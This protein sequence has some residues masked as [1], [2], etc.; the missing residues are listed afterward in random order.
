M[1]EFN[2]AFYNGEDGYSDGDDAENNIYEIVKAGRN[3]DDISAEEM[4]WPAFY[5]LS[6]IRE[7]ICNWYPFKKNAKILEIGSGCGAITGVLCQNARMVTSIELSK[8]RASINFERNKKYKNLEIIVGNLNEIK[9]DE[10]YDYITLIGVL[11]YAGRFTEGDNPFHL[12]INNIKRFLKPDGAILIAIENRLGLKYFCGAPED[13]TGRLFD[14]INNYPNYNGVK[15]FSKS[16]LVEL[17]NECGFIRNRFYYPYPDYK[18]PNEIFTD[19]S[20]NKNKRPY[21]TYDVDRYSL[22]WETDMNNSLQKENVAFAFANSFFVEARET[23]ECDA[24]VL[25]VK[26]NQDRKEEFRVGTVIY[27]QDGKKN[28]EK[29]IFHPSAISHIIN[30]Y[31]NDNKKYGNV[32]TINGI[33]NDDSIIY[34]LIQSDSLSD[35]LKEL[36]LHG[37]A[38]E[39][40]DLIRDFFDDVFA[41][42]IPMEL[43]DDLVRV[44]GETFPNE[45]N[46]KC[47]CP[48]NIDLSPSNVFCVD[49]SYVVSD[50]E[51]VFDFPIP[52][53][54][55][56]WRAIRAL[57]V[58]VP[59]ISKA[60]TEKELLFDLQIYN[61]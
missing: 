23:T 7:G 61:N 27:Q 47:V 39:V 49:D 20:I 57:Y 30:I 28:V 43:T 10:K 38:S 45:I 46:M 58:N 56:A 44:F 8:R 42:A 25:Y 54:F 16:E 21:N 12:F 4:T 14:G 52:V 59:Q 36:A 19:Y 17:L 11:E 37:K 41:D 6:P 9:L 50:C 55:V 5:H 13:H 48:A 35:R 32:N 34:P 40:V 31:E 2:L 22:F 29:K 33:L 24:S 60:I 1:A 15:T 51:W 26:L 18:L 3:L 53:S